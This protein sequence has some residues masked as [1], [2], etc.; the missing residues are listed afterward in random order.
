MDLIGKKHSNL[1][2]ETILILIQIFFT[3]QYQLNYNEN[4]VKRGILNLLKEC[5]VPFQNTQYH[6]LK[7]LQQI[8]R[9]PKILELVFSEEIV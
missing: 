9:Y 4:I 8:I 5:G 6:Y 3:E 2:E 1:S 7:I